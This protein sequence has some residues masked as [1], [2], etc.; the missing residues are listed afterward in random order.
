MK[1]NIIRVL[2]LA[3][4]ASMLFGLAACS[5]EIRVRFVKE[6]GSDIDFEAIFGG[7]GGGSATPANNDSMPVDTTPVTDASPATDASPVTDASPATDA[8]PATTAAPSGSNTPATTAAPATSA[9]PTSS[10]PSGTQAIV[11]F[12]KAAVTK[13]KNEGC[14]SYTKKEYQTIYDLNVTGN[15]MVDGK[16][17]DVA[18]GY[19]KDESQADTQTAT[20]GDDSSKSKM[21][22][23][24]LTDYSKVKSATCTA[25][26]SNYDITIVMQDEDTPRDGQ[27]FLQKIGSVLIWEDIEAELKN[28]SILSGYDNVHILYKDYTIKATITPDGKFVSMTHHTDITIQIGMAKILIITLK[29]KSVGMANDAVFTGFQY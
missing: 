14:A 25:N 15:G 3:L 2:A 5:Q 4:V 8:A 9:Q 1:K 28:V 16:I 12:Y 18:A 22:A 29:D 13:V 19:F 17:K 21:I 6:D 11:D 26:G 23:C 24:T 20:K 10:M 27:S 7:N